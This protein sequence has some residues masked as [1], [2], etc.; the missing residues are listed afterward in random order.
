[1]GDES[2]GEADVVAEELAESD[3]CPLCVHCRSLGESAL[4][5][6]RRKDL[7]DSRRG[8]LLNASFFLSPHARLMLELEIQI[9][10]SIGGVHAQ[11]T[12][13]GVRGSAGDAG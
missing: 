8:G 7:Y 3:R 2:P 12:C 9:P 11:E 10:R 6:A 13:R 1:S 4:R 5:P